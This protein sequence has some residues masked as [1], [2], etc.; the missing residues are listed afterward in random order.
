MVISRP[1]GTVLMISST[2]TGAGMTMVPS[3]QTFFCL[4][5]MVSTL[6]RSLL[7]ISFSRQDLRL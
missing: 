1:S 6:G 3:P 2:S 5:A 4:S 7:S